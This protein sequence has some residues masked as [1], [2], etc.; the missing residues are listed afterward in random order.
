MVANAHQHRLGPGLAAAARTALE[1]S[2]NQWTDLRAT[3]F[4]TLSRLARPASAYEIADEVSKS[5][6]RRVA[7]NTVYRILDLFVAGKIAVRVESTNAYIVN[8]HPDCPHDC[9][10]MVCDGCGVTSH[11]DDDGIAGDIRT[12]AGQT[13]FAPTR[14]VLEVRGRCAACA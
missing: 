8:T 12:A 1:Q 13:G 7:P 5:A 4:A 11:L 2:G 3:V 10:F 6:N 14:L 9:I